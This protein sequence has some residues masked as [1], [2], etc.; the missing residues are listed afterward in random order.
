MCGLSFRVHDSDLY[1]T[2]LTGDIGDRRKRTK[3]A[4]STKEQTNTNTQMC[5]DYTYILHFTFSTLEVIPTAYCQN[6]VV[7]VIVGTVW[8]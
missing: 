8:V 4:H 7:L 6:I 5:V 1:N 3:R 2:S